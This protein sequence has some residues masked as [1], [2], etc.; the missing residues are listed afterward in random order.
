MEIKGSDGGGG[1]RGVEEGF[2]T[3]GGSTTAPVTLSD[4]IINLSGK[5]SWQF[6]EARH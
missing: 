2:E 6:S 1:R 3:E 4:V 5:C